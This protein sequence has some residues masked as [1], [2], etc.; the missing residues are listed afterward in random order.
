M[1]RLLLY[2]VISAAAGGKMLFPYVER[3]NIVW[4]GCH[5]Y[6]YLKVIK[7]KVYIIS[8]GS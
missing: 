4:I 8:Q 1:A 3:R 5:L 6:P 7:R 2:L